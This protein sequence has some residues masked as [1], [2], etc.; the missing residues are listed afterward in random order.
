MTEFDNTHPFMANVAQKPFIEL[1][2]IGYNLPHILSSDN[3][4]F[5]S[6]L[7]P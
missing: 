4:F 7:L 1:E 2:H 3:Q 6:M 5:V